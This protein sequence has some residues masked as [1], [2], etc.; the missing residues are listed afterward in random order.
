MSRHFV[1]CFPSGGAQ[2]HT[3]RAALTSVTQDAMRHN[4]AESGVAP[5]RRVL[6]GTECLNRF[7]LPTPTLY[8]V[9]Q[10]SIPF[11]LTAIKPVTVAFTVRYCRWATRY[12]LHIISQNIIS[13]FFIKLLYFN[14]YLKY[15]SKTNG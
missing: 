1:L 13:I 8:G 14:F 10:V 9:K 5:N 7:Y 6:M 11:L 2:C 3:F 4:L 12:L 15:C